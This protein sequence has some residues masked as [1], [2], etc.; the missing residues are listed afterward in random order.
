MYAEIDKVQKNRENCMN[1][2]QTIKTLMRIYDHF[3]TKFDTYSGDTDELAKLQAVF[4]SEVESV[5]LHE[6]VKWKAIQQ[7]KGG[8]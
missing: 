1:Y 3:Y 8:D 2:Y 4:V 5:L 6:S 7:S